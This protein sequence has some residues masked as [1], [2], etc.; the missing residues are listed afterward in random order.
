M[1]F[2]LSPVFSLQQNQRTRG[3]NR[4]CL[5]VWGVGKVTQTMNTHV[6]KHKNEKIKERKNK[7]TLVGLTTFEVYVRAISQKQ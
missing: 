1:S 6:S 7:Q 4:F 5:D 2:L 3:Q